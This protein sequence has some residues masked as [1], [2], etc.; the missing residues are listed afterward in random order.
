MPP[1]DL[2]PARV[3]TLQP[4]VERTVR[5]LVLDLD[6]TVRRSKRGPD[7]F[8]EGPD[9]VELFPGAE[10]AIHAYRRAT[11]ALVLGF[12]NQGGVAHGYKTPL[13]HEA[14]LRRTFELFEDSPFLAVESSFSM[15]GGKTPGYG[16]RSLLRKP[17]YG[18][19]AVLEWRL[20]TEH[21]LAVRW[22]E[23]LVVGDRPEDQE[24]AR[25]AGV[26]FGWAHDFFGRPRPDA[27]VAAPPPT[28]DRL[29]AAAADAGRAIHHARP[30]HA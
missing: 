6:G 15:L 10:A 26:P 3:H 30:D 22:D 21:A 12:T 14:E 1:Q 27:P 25:A 7:A 11:G 13:D 8:I 9:D 5:A 28:D 29:K 24:A 17:Y 16:V 4:P 2:P 19:L 23:S 20:R 18:M